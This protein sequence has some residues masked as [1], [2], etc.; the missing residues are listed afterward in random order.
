MSNPVKFAARTH[1]IEIDYAGLSLSIP[2]RVKFRYRLEGIDPDWQNVGTRR[3]AYYDNLGP[4]SYRFR[5]IACNNDGVWNESGASIDFSIA[6]AYYQTTWFAVLCTAVLAGLLWAFYR[7][8]LHQIRQH[9]KAGFEVR[10]AE[11]TRIAQELHDTLLQSFQGLM[12]RFQTIRNMLP[13]RPLEAMRVLDDALERADAALDESRSAIQNIRNFD[14]QPTDLLQALKGAVAEMVDQYCNQ[15]IHK[16]TFSI[17]NEGSPRQLNQWVSA[18]VLHIAQEAFRNSLQHASARQIEADV[19]YGGSLFR[20]RLRD[21]GVGIDPD[22]LK[23]GGRMGHWGII[24]MRER[25]AQ[26]GAKLDVWSKPGAGTELDLR[27]PA[28]I[29]Y[30]EFVGENGRHALR[31]RFKKGT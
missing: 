10:L 8:R 16:P 28:R 17:L 2:E 21:D 30:Q 20:I 22:I 3:Q 7:F 23:D 11:R 31:K 15:G 26:I 12:L 19:T 27:I 29:A 18:E 14:G 4:G 5:V 1:H 9:F 24:G 6:P 13:V 25:A